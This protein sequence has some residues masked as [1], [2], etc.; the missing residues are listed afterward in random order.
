LKGYGASGKKILKIMGGRSTED[1]V[2][3]KAQSEL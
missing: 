3:I 2:E 1:E